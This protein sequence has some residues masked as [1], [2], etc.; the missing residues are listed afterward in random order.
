MSVFQNIR[1]RNKAVDSH[2]VAPTAGKFSAPEAITTGADNGVLTGGQT[3]KGVIQPPLEGYGSSGED[4]SRVSLEERN[5]FEI[6]KNGNAIT[7]CAQL[8]VKKAEAAALV[9]SRKAV[10]LT[11]GWI[12]VCFF[13]LALQ[14]SILSNVTYYAYATSSWPPSWARP[15]SWRPSSGACSSCPLPRCSTS[16][17]APRASCSSSAS[18]CSA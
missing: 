4:S 18:T 15:A 10:L 8:G 11:Y 16:G 5:E 14:Q 1:G 12:W 13:M 9:W 2:V 17:V 3:E 7:D 6:K